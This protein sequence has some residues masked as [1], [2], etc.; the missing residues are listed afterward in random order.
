[1]RALFY[2]LYH[3][4]NLSI[5]YDHLDYPSLQEILRTRGS[6]VTFLVPL[7]LK[8]WMTASGVQEN[9]IIEMDWW[10][11]VALPAMGVGA[12]APTLNFVCVPAQHTSGEL[13]SALICIHITKLV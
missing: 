4:L 3:E 9:R 8:S 12:P 1:M 10:D 11:E 6:Q 7:G 2:V 13:D 5:S